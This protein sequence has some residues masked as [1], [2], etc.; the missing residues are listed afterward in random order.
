M[1]ARMHAIGGMCA[2]GDVS[3]V[4]WM[5]ARRVEVPGQVAVSPSVLRLVAHHFAACGLIGRIRRT[6]SQ[7]EAQALTL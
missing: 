7:T 1:C 5:R 2:A 6:R 3:A 4:K